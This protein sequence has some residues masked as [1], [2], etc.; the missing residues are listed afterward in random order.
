MNRKIR[1]RYR[2]L[3]SACSGYGETQTPAGLQVPCSRCDGR[4][5][6]F[7]LPGLEDGE[8]KRPMG[9]PAVKGTH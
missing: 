7:A 2:V 5:W 4:G 1:E 8:M 6:V 3:C 9:W